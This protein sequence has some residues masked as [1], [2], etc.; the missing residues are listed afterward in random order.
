MAIDEETLNELKEAFD[1]FDTS[2][3]NC[4]DARELKAAMKA[5]GIEAKKEDI[6]NSMKNIGKEISDTIVF[7][8]FVKIMLP[9]LVLIK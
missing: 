5:F 8:E 4:I 7:E 9:K 1:L 6:R 3:N 2:H